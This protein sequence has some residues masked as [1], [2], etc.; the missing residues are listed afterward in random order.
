MIWKKEFCFESTVKIDKLQIGY[1]YGDDNSMNGKTRYCNTMLPRVSRT[2]APTIRMLPKKLHLPVTVAYLL[3]RI[4]D[5]IEDSETLSV[6]EKRR[7]LELYAAIFSES[8]RNTINTLMPLVKTLPKSSADYELTHNLPIVLEVFHSFSAGVQDRIGR[9]VVEMSLGM[10]KYAQCAKKRRFNLLRTMKEL[11]EY[12]YY[13]AGTVGYLL[14]EL[15]SYYS[16]K[17]TPAVRSKLEKLAEPFGKGLQMVNIIRDMT[18]DLKRGQTYLPEELLQKYNLTYPEIFQKENAGRVEQ[19]FTE[20]IRRTIVDLDRALDYVLLIPKKERRLRLATM[21]PLFLAI[22]TL[23]IIHENILELLNDEK[24]KIPRTTL[25]KEFMYALIN[26]YSNR[27]MR[28]HYS[29]IRAN[30]DSVFASANA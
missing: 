20:L 15:F 21:M 23:E 4:A 24:V 9:W 14:T 27:L 18:S 6:E 22:R 29:R 5:T 26:R 19:M 10:H 11:D 16:N 7:M 1:L 2:F 25:R 28:W 30:L 12:T 17:I 3:C 13:V 8:G